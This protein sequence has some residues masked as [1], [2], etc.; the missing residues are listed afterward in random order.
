VIGKVAFSFEFGTLNDLSNGRR[1]KGYD[2]LEKL[3]Q[4]VQKR[5]LSIPMLW[6]LMNVD[7]VGV[8]ESTDYLN[9]IVT[10]VIAKKKEAGMTK[11]Q[12]EMDVLDR[13]LSTASSGEDAFNEVEIRDEIIAFFIAGHE[14]T[15]NSL[16]N[17]VYELCNNPEVLEKMQK[18]I[19]DVLGDED[20]TWET[21]PSLKYLEMVIKEAM[22]LHPVI[23]ALGRFAVKN[24]QVLG[25][26]LNAGTRVTVNIA[27]M[28]R[29]PR[30]WKS[31]EK[32]MPERFEES[33]VAGS[34]MPFGNHH[35]N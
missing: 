4:K 26:K 9:G 18:E 34:Y 25:Y 19:D 12:K 17:V 32:F 2:L 27:S 8:K 11:D 22:R 23:V 13:L 3:V 10:S 30:Y 14:T 24:T 33:P 15:A 20:V 7:E 29:D 1:G 5:M 31:P 21:L 16:T 28:H 6:G 35:Q